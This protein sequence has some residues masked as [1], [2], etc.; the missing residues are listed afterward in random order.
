MGAATAGVD[1]MDNSSCAPGSG[2]GFAVGRVSPIL[3]QQISY[4]FA[5]GGADY[6][7]IFMHLLSYAWLDQ[8]GETATIIIPNQLHFRKQDANC[9]C[10]YATLNTFIRLL[11]ALGILYK[12]PR[13]KDLPAAYS[14][15]LSEYDVPPGAFCAL[16]DL[17]DPVHT[18]NK[19]VRSLA[20]HVQSRLSQ[21]RVDQQESTA[22]YSQGDLDLAAT[23]DAVQGLI[24]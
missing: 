23:L 17:V 5:D 8:P 3:R 6:E 16:N 14:L 19:R 15:S 11:R 18:K 4:L 24:S 9:P 10:C 21:L 1:F 22:R 2:C 12:R 20:K 7:G 13:R